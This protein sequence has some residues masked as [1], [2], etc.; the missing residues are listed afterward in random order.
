MNN[1]ILNIEEATQKEASLYSR[2]NE[3]SINGSAAELAKKFL[4]LIRDYDKALARF[5]GNDCD[6]SHFR[7]FMTIIDNDFVCFARQIIRSWEQKIACHKRGIYGRPQAIMKALVSQSH[8]LEAINSSQMTDYCNRWIDWILS[9]IERLELIIEKRKA[10][11]IKEAS[12]DY[13]CEFLISNL[14][15]IHSEVSTYEKITSLV[16]ASELGKTNV[17]G[18]TPQGKQLMMDI[19]YIEERSIVH[20]INSKL[21]YFLRDKLL[22]NRFILDG[23]D[24]D[25]VFDSTLTSDKKT[26]N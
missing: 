7:K 1:N 13:L 15:N 9:E 8:R 17:Y 4:E 19:P 3:K 16:L 26:K 21:L 6:Y 11:K 18:I 14:L 23:P 25:P 5:Q 10:L 22:V 20:S 24:M 2:E 12:I